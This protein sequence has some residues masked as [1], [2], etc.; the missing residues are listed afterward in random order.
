VPARVGGEA[1]KIA[2]SGQGQF[3]TPAAAGGGG[4]LGECASA[5]EFVCFTESKGEEH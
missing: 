3:L 1:G 5:G 2:S 4:G